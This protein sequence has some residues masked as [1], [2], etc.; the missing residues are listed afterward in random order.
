MRVDAIEV[1]E[2]RR[3]C[4]SGE[5]WEIRLSAGLSRAE[6]GAQ[7]GVDESTVAR[8]EAGSRA[9]RVAAAMRYAHLLRELKALVTL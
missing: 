5:A 9:P 3:L 2:V 1:A 8:W 7:V 4:R 6:V